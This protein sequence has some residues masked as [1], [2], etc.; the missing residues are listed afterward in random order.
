M[1][2]Q[3]MPLKIDHVTLAGADLKTLEQVSARAGLA[4]A[5]GGP[6]CGDGV[7]WARKAKTAATFERVLTAVTTLRQQKRDV[8]DY[9]TEACAA[10]V[11]GDK[12]PSLPPDAPVINGGV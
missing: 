10:A 11:R 3:A 1:N 4:T 5:C 7:A 2:E 12:A 9:L 8:L 6:S